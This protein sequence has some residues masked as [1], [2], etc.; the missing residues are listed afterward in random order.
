MLLTSR[1]LQGVFG[2]LLTPS[3]LATLAAT[4]PTPAERGKAF[5][6]YGTAMGSQR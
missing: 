4:F 5:G 1:A 3:V 2:A 6:I